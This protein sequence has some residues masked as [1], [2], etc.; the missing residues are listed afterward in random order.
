[1]EVDHDV[2]RENIEFLVKEIMEVE[3]GKKKKEKV[4]EWKKKAEEAVEVGRLSYIDF[5]RFFKEALKHG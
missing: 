2:K 3:E 1:M 5:D 4:L